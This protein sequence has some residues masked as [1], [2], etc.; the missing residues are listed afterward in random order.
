MKKIVQFNSQSR[1]HWEYEGSHFK[2]QSFPGPPIV[3]CPRHQ[4][5]LTRLCLIE[6][7]IGTSGSPPRPP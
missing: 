2:Q 4:K 6:W 5:V 1:E 7:F 3:R